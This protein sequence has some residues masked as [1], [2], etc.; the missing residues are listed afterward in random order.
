MKN[1]GSDEVQHTFT[2]EFVSAH[3]KNVE[4][5]VKTGAIKSQSHSGICQWS[6]IAAPYLLYLCCPYTY[7][8]TTTATAYCHITGLLVLLYYYT[9]LKH[10]RKW[11]DIPPVGTC[12]DYVLLDYCIRHGAAVI[13]LC[14]GVWEKMCNRVSVS[15]VTPGFIC[16]S[17]LIFSNLPT[18]FV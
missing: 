1:S 18:R 6:Q 5:V 10:T 14:L 8:S 3:R 4:A 11:K 9:V 15:F 7:R 13:S 2:Q 12:L 17:R 16:L